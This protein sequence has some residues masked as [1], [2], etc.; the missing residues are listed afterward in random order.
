MYRTKSSLLGPLTCLQEGIYGPLFYGV[1]KITRRARVHICQ[2]WTLME[3]KRTASL[4][5]TFSPLCSPFATL[6][7]LPLCSHTQSDWVLF[8]D[9]LAPETCLSQNHVWEKRAGFPTCGVRELERARSPSCQRP[10]PVQSMARPRP[11]FVG[12]SGILWSQ[13]APPCVSLCMTSAYG[14]GLT[15]LPQRITSSFLR[16]TLFAQELLA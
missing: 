1:K 4:V 12:E 13:P 9:I 16:M 15:K 8:D 2:G 7:Y 11:V 3:F 5:C 10:G 6:L 14:I